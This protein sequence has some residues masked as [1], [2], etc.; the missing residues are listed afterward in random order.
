MLEINES[1]YNNLDYG[2]LISSIDLKDLTD[3]MVSL[4]TEEWVPHCYWGNADIT[5]EPTFRGRLYW[6]IYSY[7]V[8][9]EYIRIEN[10][11]WIERKGFGNHPNEYYEYTSYYN[12]L[13]ESLYKP[14]L[15]RLDMG[16]YLINVDDI[17]WIK[18]D[19][20]FPFNIKKHTK[21]QWLN[22][23]RWR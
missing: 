2:D 6:A 22:M 10:P 9:N 20:S 3:F 8:K 4:T 13:E 14:I 16:N 1:N 11:Y 17:Y 21:K 18:S 23:I 7:L 12:P 15:T 5:T 19:E